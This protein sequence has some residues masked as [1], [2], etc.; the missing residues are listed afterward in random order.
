MSWFKKKSP[1]TSFVGSTLP[2]PDDDSPETLPDPQGVMKLERAEAVALDALL[3]RKSKEDPGRGT[4]GRMRDLL[5][6]GPAPVPFVGSGEDA[7]PDMEEAEVKDPLQATQEEVAANVTTAVETVLNQPWEL[8]VKELSEKHGLRLADHR[9]IEEQKAAAMEDVV[10]RFSHAP[11]ADIEKALKFLD[12]AQ[13]LLNEGYEDIEVS[14]I[15]GLV[16][17]VIHLL[18]KLGTTLNPKKS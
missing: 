18:R 17:K 8:V 9:E 6:T 1:P 5:R 3:G 14:S 10:A 2:E 15:D 11:R 4:Y 13:I 12:V 7:A 16:W